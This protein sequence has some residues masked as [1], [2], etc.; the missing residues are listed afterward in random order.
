MA[1][2]FP[3]VFRI[4]MKKGST[5]AE[6]WSDEQADWNLGFRRG[7]RDQEVDNWIWLIVLLPSFQFRNAEDKL[8]WNLEW[9]KQFSTK[10][11][12]YKLT[13]VT[14]KFL[15][16]FIKAIWK[17]SCPK[18]V[19]VFLRSLAYRSL[20]T[21]GECRRSFQIGCCPYRYVPYALEM[22]KILIIYSFIVP[23]PTKGGPLS[24]E[25]AEFPIV[26]PG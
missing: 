26:Y 16:P 10:S 7:L 23:L 18:K 11:A 14:P 13:E 15:S 19:K 22:P 4:S 1:A 17:F 25:D 6:C 9:E 2:Q 24:C 12:F 8:M 20:N 3:D 5:V 21:H